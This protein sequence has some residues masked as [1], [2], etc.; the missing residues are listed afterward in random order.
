MAADEIDEYNPHPPPTTGLALRYFRGGDHAEMLRRVADY[1]DR[2]NPGR[3]IV[4]IRASVAPDDSELV[5]EVVVEHDEDAYED[6]DDYETEVARVASSEGF[7][8]MLA[9]LRTRPG[10]WRLMATVDDEFKAAALR[11]AFVTSAAELLPSEKF[12]F[13]YRQPEVGKFCVYA[14]CEPNA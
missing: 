12:G 2:S 10:M 5:L 3:L 11:E 7:G 6:V 1:I 13:E 4:A 9:E 14:R 8:E